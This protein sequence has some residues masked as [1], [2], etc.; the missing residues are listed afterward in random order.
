MDYK[1]L[2]EEIRNNYKKNP[3]N[4]FDVSNPRWVDGTQ[5]SHIY[6]DKQ[7]LAKRG[8]IVYGS[9]IQ[10][11]EN[12]FRLTPERDD[13]CA[14]ILYSMD[15]YYDEHPEELQKLSKLFGSYKN[16]VDE[17]PE[18]IRHFIEIIT[19]EYD[20]ALSLELPKRLTPNG[21]VYYSSIMIW[22][23]HL[24][25]KYLKVFLV[26]IFANPDE[27]KSCIIVPKEYWCNDYKQYYNTGRFPREDILLDKAFY[28]AFPKT[29][30]KDVEFVLNKIPNKTINNV[31]INCT[32]STLYNLDGET[33]YLPYRVYNLELDARKIEE[34]SNIQKMIYCSIFS[35][36]YNGFTRQKN[37]QELLNMD[38]EPWV[39]PFLIDI[40]SEYI[41][42]ILFDI[43]SSIKDNT[44][45][46]KEFCSN[47]KFTI[48][49]NYSRMYSYYVTQYSEV[50]KFEDYV[51]KKL[52]LDCFGYSKSWAKHNK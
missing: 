50:F 21:K 48:Y 15:P 17:T 16:R 4:D 26:P 30:E 36:S 47:N 22:R 9:I 2:I 13:H 33:I 10:A 43:Y 23:K 51:G 38:Y 27:V 29:L 39:I 3:L 19:D 35:R 12:I 18:D 41:I 42:E 37:I 5:I 28:K 7:K 34:F 52:Y 40:S 31:N 25:D 46:F 6:F 44:T 24:I 1:K 14:A 32:G 11:H 49:R 8:K 45:A 20:Y